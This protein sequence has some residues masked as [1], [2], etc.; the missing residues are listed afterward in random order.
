V[1]AVELALVIGRKLRH[2]YNSTAHVNPLSA[3]QLIVMFYGP[4]TL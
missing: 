1:L 3:N 2:S 4:P